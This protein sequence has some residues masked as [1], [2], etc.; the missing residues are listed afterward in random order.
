MAGKWF[1]QGTLVSSI[2]ITDGHDITEVLLKVPLNTNNTKPKKNFPV[3]N[4]TNVCLNNSFW[5]CLVDLRSNN[6]YNR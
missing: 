6:T 3:K 5:V 2:M 4:M 1:S